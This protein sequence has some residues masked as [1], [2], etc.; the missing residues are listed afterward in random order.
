MIYEYHP[1]ANIF[2][3]IE[4]Q[5]YQDL[6]ADVLK[7]GVREPVWLYEGQILDGRNRYR[8]ASAMG[9][10]FATRVYEGDFDEA[11]EFVLSLNLHRRQ[12]TPSQLA[13]LS[14][15]IE[16]LEAK[17]AKDRQIRKP[18]ESV[19]ASLPQQNV[20]AGKARDKAAKA[21]G[22]SAR[23]VT[24][25]KKVKAKR[26]DLF[27]QV[28]SGDL[29]L[30]AAERSMKEAEQKADLE[31]PVTIELSGLHRGDF[32]EL[33]KSI[34]DESVELI[35]TDPPYDGDSVGLYE[36]AAMVAARILKPGGS[37]I[38]YSGQSHLSEVLQGMSKHMRYWWTVA[39]VHEGGNQILNKLGIRCG[40]KPLVWFVKSY[41]GDVQNV[42]LDVVRGDREKSEH[43]WQQAQS[44]AEYFI[45]ELCPEGGT[46]VDFFL[47]GG[48]TAAACK[49][50]GRKC[51]GFEVDATAFEK[52][53][54]RLAA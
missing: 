30:H 40:W 6:M 43:K 1:L 28:V 54:E 51:I 34:P 36:D 25:A 21:T 41:R 45:R 22:A 16:E 47:G 7:H 8:A 50:T 48:T 15:T 26:P 18:A 9:V 14:L 27:V 10:E 52:S 19:V 5:A 38:A 32:R 42:I 44:E 11:M 12:L 31:R 39:G 53:V 46:V 4:G 2:P 29:T 49:A 3:L 35:F 13:A 24:K 37:L 20:D 17:R 33:S 23:N